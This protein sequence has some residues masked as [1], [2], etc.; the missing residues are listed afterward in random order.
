MNNMNEGLSFGESI[1]GKAAIKVSSLLS[2]SVKNSKDVC[3]LWLLG[4]PT[5]PIELLKENLKTDNEI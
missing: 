4:E 1:K 5:Y 2:N 3:V